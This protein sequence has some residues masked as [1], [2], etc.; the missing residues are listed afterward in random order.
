[1]G[2]SAFGL[3][4]QTAEVFK[5]INNV[6][7]YFLVSKYE[8]GSVSD[9]LNNN[10]FKFEYVPTGYIGRSNLIWTLITIVQIPIL[11]IKIFFAYFRNNCKSIVVLNTLPVINA[12]LLF[13]LFKYIFRVKIYF[14][15][16]NI[17]T[18]L[19]VFSGFFYNII[20]KISYK[21][22][23]VSCFVK[24][25][26]IEQGIS[27]EKIYVVYNGVKIKKFKKQYNSQI[28]KK[29]NIGLGEKII[30]FVGQL[31]EEK[32]IIDFIDAA[33]IILNDNKD[34]KFLIVGKKNNYS[35][36]VLMEY[37]KKLGFSE[38]FIFTDWIKDVENYYSILNVLVVPSQIEEAFG[39]VNI[40]AMASEVPVVATN[41]GG[42]KEIIV[43]G[44]T[45]YL[46][47]KNNPKQISER[48]LDIIN[49]EKLSKKMG[50]EGRLRVENLFNIEKNSKRIEEYLL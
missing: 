44:K 4:K 15:F 33:K 43:D 11:Y 22:I 42:M 39:L 8:D 5:F 25:K 26:Y 31:Y 36:F 46:V 3:E 6:E 40:E 24:Y 20:N 48:I 12:T 16:H 29:H 41:V 2:A 17:P 32:G 47:E 30:G 45:G 50:E 35:S 38:Y 18:D 37:I 28:L 23:V 21:V 27:E 1:M 7:P 19:K 49:D 34:Y 14:Y 9:L 13:L 10:S